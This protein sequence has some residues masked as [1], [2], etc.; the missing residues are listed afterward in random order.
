LTDWLEIRVQADGEAAEAASALFSRENAR[1]DGQGGAV[2]EVSGFDPVGEDHHP[3]VTV[4]TYLLAEAADTAE[5]RRRIEE[6]L[7][8]LGR[9]HPLG[10]VQIRTIADEDWSNAGRPATGRCA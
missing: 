7:W 10:E 2:T 4:V 6:G 8:Y 3:V 1:P 9:I 5:R